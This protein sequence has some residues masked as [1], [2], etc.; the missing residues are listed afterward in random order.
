ARLHEI[1]VAAGDDVRN[2][3]AVAAAARVA[4]ANELVEG[5]VYRLPDGR[6]RLDLRR[7]RLA[8]GELLDTYRVTG[9]DPFELVDRATATLAL[10]IGGIGG[11]RLRVADVTTRS[12]VALRF[13]QE[14]LDSYFGGDAATGAHLF[15]AALNED[16]TF[17]MAAYFAG[18]AN[19]ND[20]PVMRSYL[21][22]AERLAHRTT[23]RERLLIRATLAHFLNEPEHLAIA[24]SMVARYPDEPAA[25]LL[26]GR[27][28]ML[29][30]RFADAMGPLRRAVHLD[31]LALQRERGS[32]RACEALLSMGDAYLFLDSTAAAERT[33]RR[34]Y[35][36]RAS[37]AAFAAPLA[38]ALQAN[39]KYAEADELWRRAGAAGMPAENVA[40]GLIANDIRRG[41]F[42][43]ADAALRGFIDKS[44]RDLR[45]AGRWRLIISLRNQGRLD[46]ALAVVEKERLDPGGSRAFPPMDLLTE[47]I[48][49]FERGDFTHAAALF[50]SLAALV[51]HEGFDAGWS[52]N[53]AWNLTHAANAYASAGRLDLLGSLADRVQ[54]VGAGSGY[55]R[56]PRLHHHVRGLLAAARGD[57]E[58]AITEFRAAVYSIASGYTRTNVELARS[59]LAVGRPAEAVAVLEPPVRNGGLDAMMFYTTRTELHALLG[60]AL[61][62]AGQPE[63]ARI[64]IDQAL[65]GWQ[66]ADATFTERVARLRAL[67][68][69]RS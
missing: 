63:R 29:A 65:H 3:S 44:T 12:L 62:G 15:G 21:E 45:S 40:L 33:I 10:D 8:D 2:A 11:R 67:R 36:A 58:T 25:H 23:A 26:Y 38:N 46:D 56:D 68:E 66:N 50:D 59:L 7:L 13:Y 55:G 16:S 32:C 52:R 61:L 9:S 49:R 1:A 43:R 14:G 18:L 48:V 17:A 54:T 41:E 19:I 69:G 39:G 60:E 20:W 47:A 35:D 24:D 28:L 27:S 37:T 57:H 30:G 5:A 42:V 34:A 22:R 6:L 31:S 4:H 51:P 53:V 64:H